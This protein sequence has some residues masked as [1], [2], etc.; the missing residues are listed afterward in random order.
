MI[1]LV[2]TLVALVGGR[3][4][5]LF[6]S[7]PTIRDMGGLYLLCQA[8]IFPLTGAGLACYFAGLGIGVSPNRSPW[9]F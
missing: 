7:D 2:F 1:G 3:W 6:T 4:M 5:S 8:A 9:R